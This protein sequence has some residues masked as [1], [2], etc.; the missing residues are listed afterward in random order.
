M[1][2]AEDRTRTGR[3]GRGG[4]AALAIGVLPLVAALV[5]CSITSVALARPVYDPSQ[6]GFLGPRSCILPSTTPLIMGVALPSGAP[7]EAEAVAARL[8][9]SGF[10][11]R[12]AL[13]CPLQSGA[14]VW[15]VA[16]GRQPSGLEAEPGVM[17]PLTPR[18]Y[19]PADPDLPL[20]VWTSWRRNAVTQP[21]GALTVRRVIALVASSDQAAETWPP[22]HSQGDEVPLLSFGG[23]APIEPLGAI[24]RSAPA[25]GWG[26]LVTMLEPQH[27]EGTA[28]R[29]LADGGPRWIGLEVM[30]ADL[31][32]TRRWLQDHG[33]S[34]RDADFG[35]ATLF[36]PPEQAG[37]TL[38]M[39]RGPSSP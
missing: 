4:N 27:G 22:P 10:W 13:V 7:Q 15:L 36:V 39:F 2:H 30:V 32:A 18:S 25:G 20:G 29:L 37:G 35:G 24:G 19:E 34:A 38:F 16:G 5:G 8:G 1:G 9:F 3:L 14:V 21:N 28:A 26:A 11:D 12:D 31:E 6:Y 17:M 33:V 23:P